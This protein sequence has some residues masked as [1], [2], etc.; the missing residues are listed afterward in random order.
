MFPVKY[1]YSDGAVSSDL[2]IRRLPYPLTEYNTNR[3]AV[4]AAAA[5]LGGAD[6]CGTK[7]WW[8]KKAH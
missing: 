4:T 3:E 6:N 7:L 8:D 5:L 1:N 2:Q